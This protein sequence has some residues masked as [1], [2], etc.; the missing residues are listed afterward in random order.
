MKTGVRGAMFLGVRSLLH[1]PV[2]C[3]YVTY[4]Q[5]TEKGAQ[6]SRRGNGIILEPFAPEITA[7]FSKWR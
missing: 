6:Q 5:N 7:R 1:L 3:T 4:M 2:A